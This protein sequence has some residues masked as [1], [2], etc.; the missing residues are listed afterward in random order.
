[1][2][3]ACPVVDKP[4]PHVRAPARRSF[5]HGTCIREGFSGGGTSCRLPVGHP[6]R[7]EDKLQV[8]TSLSQ[9]LRRRWRGI[10]ATAQVLTLLYH[11]VSE[12]LRALGELG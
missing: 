7:N 9:Q 1:M 4:V 12:A 3:I 10:H 6:P 2:F 8:R 5:G 11:S